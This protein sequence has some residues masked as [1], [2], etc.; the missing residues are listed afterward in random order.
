MPRAVRVRNRCLALLA[1]R[2]ALPVPGDADLAEIGSDVGLLDS[3]RQWENAHRPL[4]AE[5]SARGT[6]V[7][8]GS[9]WRLPSRSRAVKVG[10]VALAGVM[11]FAIGERLLSPPPRDV[12]TPSSGIVEPQW[13]S[14]TDSTISALDPRFVHVDARRGVTPVSLSVTDLAALILESP[15]RRP[16]SLDSVQVRADSLLWMRGR[17]R[18]AATFE[19]GGEIRVIRRGLAELRVAHLTINGANAPPS[20]IAS[21]VNRGRVRPEEADRIRFE[22]PRTVTGLLV[23]DGNVNVLAP[24]SSGR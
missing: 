21:L 19:L 11:G 18:G 7:R 6:P 9:R 12:E 4:P 23:A 17:V 10:A 8:R 2:R 1:A 5:Q 16:G 15:R 13:L 20:M 14:V 3:F 24:L 22:I